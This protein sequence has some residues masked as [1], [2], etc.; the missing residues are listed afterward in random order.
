MGNILRDD[1][2]KI[3]KKNWA[4]EWLIVIMLFSPSAV[5]SKG[6]VLMGGIL[7]V[8]SAAYF[9]SLS[10]KSNLAQSKPLVI[11]LCVSLIGLTAY[12]ICHWLFFKSDEAAYLYVFLIFLTAIMGKFLGLFKKEG[13]E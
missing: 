6:H 11:F 2:L 8:I 13:V 9:F 5:I 7:F 1:Q 12:S 3:F 10:I 4:H